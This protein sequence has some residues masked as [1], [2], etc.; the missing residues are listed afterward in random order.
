MHSW[1]TK[2]EESN[3]VFHIFMRLCY[4]AC[5]TVAVVSSAE[6]NSISMQNPCLDVWQYY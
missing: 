5:V 1:L 4:C 3:L 6:Y 2:W